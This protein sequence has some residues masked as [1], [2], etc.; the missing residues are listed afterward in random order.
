[1]GLL[2]RN[3]SVTAVIIK[4]KPICNVAI[5]RGDSDGAQLS[6]EQHVKVD[7]D[8]HRF[9]KAYYTKIGR[10]YVH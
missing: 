4:S 1:M 2:F 9:S 6:Q 5:I 3:M 10:L 7:D 8:M